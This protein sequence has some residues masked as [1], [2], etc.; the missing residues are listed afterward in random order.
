MIFK[1]ILFIVLFVLVR[2]VLKLS[3][4]DSSTGP[5]IRNRSKRGRTWSTSVLVF[6]FGQTDDYAT[7]EYDDDR[8]TSCAPAP[9]ADHDRSRR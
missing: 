7:C 6:A 2:T 5:I 8:T 9:T 3:I 4:Y 1:G